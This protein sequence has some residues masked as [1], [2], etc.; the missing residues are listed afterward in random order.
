MTIAQRNSLVLHLDFVVKS[1]VLRAMLNVLL[2][3]SS[4]DGSAHGFYLLLLLQMVRGFKSI[5]IHRQT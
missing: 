4:K 3:L 5:V 2:S 1:F